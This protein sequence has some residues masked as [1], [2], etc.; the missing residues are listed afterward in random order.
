MFFLVRQHAFGSGVILDPDGYIMT[1][2]TSSKEPDRSVSFYHR[3][4]L[5]HRSTLRL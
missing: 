1:N 4:L 5:T 3:Q 2:A